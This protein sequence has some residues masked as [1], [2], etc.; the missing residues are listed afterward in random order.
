[1]FLLSPYIKVT[2]RSSGTLICCSTYFALSVLDF[3]ES[4]LDPN[5]ARI[6]S[7]NNTK[8]TWKNW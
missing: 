5:I 1:M 4:D 7:T 2:F 3:C 6:T 8:F